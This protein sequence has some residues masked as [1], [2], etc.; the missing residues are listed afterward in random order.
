VINIRNTRS[1]SV[2]SDESGEGKGG[3]FGKLFEGVSKQ[4]QKKIMKKLMKLRGGTK[5]YDSPKSARSFAKG[6]RGSQMDE[7]S[8]EPKDPNGQATFSTFKIHE[9]EERSEGSSSLSDEPVGLKNLD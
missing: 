3:G 5:S 2:S 7:N 1:A 4:D 8:P 6:G 9:Q